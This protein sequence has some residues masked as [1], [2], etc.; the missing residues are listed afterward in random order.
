MKPKGSE[1]GPSRLDMVLV[2]RGLAAS[3]ARARDL[4]KRGLVVVAGKIETRPAAGVA[5]GAPI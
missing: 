2:K 1:T 5:E 4:I 3:R